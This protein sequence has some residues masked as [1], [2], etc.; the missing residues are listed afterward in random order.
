MKSVAGRVA[1]DEP[2]DAL[3]CCRAGLAAEIL[4]PF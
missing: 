3:F 1:G 2:F 4:S